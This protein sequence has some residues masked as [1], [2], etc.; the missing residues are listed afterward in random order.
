M[1][2]EQIYVLVAQN[3]KSKIWKLSM[4]AR[5]TW[6]GIYAGEHWLWKKSV[7]C[8]WKLFSCTMSYLR[9]PV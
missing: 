1:H 9:G 8:G 5:V 4:Q 6:W 7:G 3:I 2:E